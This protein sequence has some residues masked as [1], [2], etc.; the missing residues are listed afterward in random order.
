MM[1][2]LFCWVNCFRIREQYSGG[3]RST[4]SQFLHFISITNAT[5][6]F[7]VNGIMINDVD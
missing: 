1:F 6:I 3:K 5:F 2:R 7:S 4:L